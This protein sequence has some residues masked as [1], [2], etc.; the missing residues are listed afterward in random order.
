MADAEIKFEREGLD[1][2]IPVGSYIGDAMRRFGLK[3]AGRCTD[4]HDCA[5]TIISGG[6]LLSPLTAFESE[7][8]AS[9]DENMGDRLACHA[10]IERP[11]EIVVMTK[12]T[13]KEGPEVAESRGE[14]YRKEFSELPLEQ[15]ISELVKLEAI[16]LGDTVSYI[17]NSPYAVFEKL[18]DVMANFGMKLETKARNA[19]RP[20]EHSED[21]QAAAE[22][23][24]TKKAGRTAKKKEADI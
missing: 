24:N 9:A 6:D 16:A 10:K 1:G 4:Q 8:F 12:E 19:Q 21:S 14:K 7:Y 23:G 15:K 11:G 20:A 22:A 18:G 13:V 3:N 17:V 2:I 5:V